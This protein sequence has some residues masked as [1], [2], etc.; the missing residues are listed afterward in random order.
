MVHL[1]HN[2]LNIQGYMSC[3]LH[4]IPCQNVLKVNPDLFLRTKV[5]M[6]NKH[7]QSPTTVLV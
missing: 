2:Y 6:G 3:Y 7:M 1:W 4:V 5:S